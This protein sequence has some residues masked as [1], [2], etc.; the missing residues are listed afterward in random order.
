MKTWV[1]NALR[2]LKVEIVNEDGPRAWALCPFHQNPTDPKS[3]ATVF[4]VRT[5]GKRRNKEQREYDASGQ[6][7]CFSC[8]ERGSMRRLV[9]FIRGCTEDE[10]KTFIRKHGGRQGAKVEE[11]TQR[12]VVVRR[13][14]TTRLRF[15]MPREVIFES[16][17]SWVSGA[18]VYATG[19]GITAGE[20][21]DFGIGYAVDGRLAGRIVVPLRGRNGVLGS[22]SARTFVDEDPKYT[23]PRPEDNPD[24]T[25]VFGEHLWPTEPEQR[26]IVIVTEGALNGL[27]ARRVMPGAHLGGIGGAKNYDS[28]QAKKLATFACAIILTDPDEAGDEV[29][30]EIKRTIGRRTHVQRVRL[31][32]GKDALD[33][34]P[35]YL[36]RALARARL[37]F[38]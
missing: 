17:A 6:F 36:G 30:A 13:E 28:E 26:K 33:V 35:D 34:G 1:H 10:A 12:A 23:T 8:G 7:F 31:P 3:W 37:K 21:E 19:R 9:T 29:A 14:R 38:P 20:V 25:I 18:R 2:G 5:Y 22:Y 24:R 11:L 15:E 16:L 27:A 32:E 4:W